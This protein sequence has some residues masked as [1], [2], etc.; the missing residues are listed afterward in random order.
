MVDRSWLQNSRAKELLNVGT[1][2]EKIPPLQPVDEDDNGFAR[3]DHLDIGP[4]FQAVIAQ[5]R[6]PEIQFPSQVGA[7]RAMEIGERVGTLQRVI[8]V[9]HQVSRY[10]RARPARG[11]QD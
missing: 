7:P 10:E 6:H 11:R 1:E 2:A 5:E 4:A 8:A 9:L 3:A